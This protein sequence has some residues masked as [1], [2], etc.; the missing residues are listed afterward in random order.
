MLG[1]LLGLGLLVLGWV[2]LRRRM[3]ASGSGSGTQTGSARQVL[4]EGRTVLA[5]RATELTGTA[6]EVVSNVV[7]STRESAAEK[8]GRLRSADQSGSSGGSVG[9]PTTAQP[10]DDAPLVQDVAPVSASGSTGDA[11]TYAVG[12]TGPDVPFAD[13]IP[14]EVA[15]DPDLSTS[16]QAGDTTATTRP[17]TSTA[18]I[19][20]VGQPVTSDYISFTSD[21]DATSTATR[22][23]SAWTRREASRD[24]LDTTAG[25]SGTSFGTAQPDMDAS[26]ADTTSAEDTG[27]EP[28]G[29]LIAPDAGP[30]PTSDTG[31]TSMQ[32]AETYQSSVNDAD[33]QGSTVEGEARSADDR[34][35]QHDRRPIEGGSVDRIYTSDDPRGEHDTQDTADTI[36]RPGPVANAR[37]EEL[38]SVHI[39]PETGTSTADYQSVEVSLPPE[40]IAAIETMDE[41]G[42]AHTVDYPIQDGY[43][44][45]ATDGKVGTVSSVVRTEGAIENYMVVKEGLILKK[46]VNIPFSAVD[47]VEGDT[48]YLTIDKQYIKLMEGQETI[49]T[50]DAGP[51]I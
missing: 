34:G 46:E 13:P 36:G 17:E 10:A 35:T 5:D 14:G 24:D 48:V 4:T 50:G 20:A 38:Q 15:G 23:T 11:P 19:S 6:R 18:E 22:G 51:Q 27:G 7:R 28:E 41:H 9:I 32:E 12:A 40:T 8:A 25:A 45:E 42:P 26:S 29:L 49:H 43:H 2:F 21:D 47:R 44:V 16:G 37:R 1:R 3:G 31:T 30:A 39:T 33:A